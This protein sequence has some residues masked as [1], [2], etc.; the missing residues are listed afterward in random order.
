VSRP[1]PVPPFRP[2][3]ASWSF[4][5]PVRVR[6]G[7]GSRGGLADTL[8]DSC[9]LI[10]AT[11]RGHRQFAADPVLA[12]LLERNS[13]TWVD[14]VQPN[15]DLHW[16]EETRGAL[17]NDGFDAVIG[18]GGGSALDAAKVLAVGL[19]DDCRQT[20]L[21]ALLK[22]PG[23]VA[24]AQAPPVHAVP[25][26]AGT[27]SE[28]T[29]FA[30]IW[31][32]A[33]K[34]KHSLA[35]ET[36]FPSFAWV[37]PALTDQVPTEVT[38]A[39]GLDAI[40]QALE[41]IWNKN[42]TP[43]TLALATRAV[44]SGLFAL[45]RLCRGPGGEQWRD[46]MSEASLL[47]GLAI[48]HTRTAVCH[49]ISYPLTAHFGL[50]HGLACALSMPEVLRLGLASDDGRLAKLG[51]DLLGTTSSKEDLLAHFEALNRELGVNERCG[52]II[53]RGN[54]LLTLVPEMFTPGRAD[55]FFLPLAQSDIANI[56][57]AILFPDAQ[58]GGSRLTS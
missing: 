39:T 56:L 30:T 10:V 15:P 42:A 58:S 55:N 36:L 35:G 23:R 2:S 28:V 29:P 21:P 33:A 17:G 37:D 6:F 24:A 50:S 46:L 13:V 34:K 48:S 18:F 47:A 7:R 44:Q 9:L 1:D 3:N 38:L 11:K 16:L 27:G 26:T 52:R 57:R 43:V 32:H 20:S 51:A 40:N 54:D 4:H 41:S 45:P 19:S 25:T 49:S 8:R 14:T 12:G 53:G 31:D 22:D 5:N